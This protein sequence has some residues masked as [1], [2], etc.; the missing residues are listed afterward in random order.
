ERVA[1]R[2]QPRRRW[3]GPRVIDAHAGRQLARRGVELRGAAADQQQRDPCMLL[4]V[5]LLPAAPL[6]ALVVVVEPLALAAAGARLAHLEALAVAHVASTALAGP[7][8]GQRR[9][10]PGLVGDLGLGAARAAAAVALVVDARALGDAAA[11]AGLD[12]L[13][14]VIVAQVARVAL[15]RPVVDRADPRV[16][17]LG[18]RARP[19]RD[20][21]A[22]RGRHGGP[23]PE[24]G[25]H[26][27]VDVT[28]APGDRD[29]VLDLAELRP[30]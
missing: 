20:A 27:L 5:E 18:L 9:A 10:R 1:R 15:T 16:T 8:A 28:R 3:P 24:V 26:R 21:G 12:D 13:V 22:V 30:R 4:H 14:A 25:R 17:D 7:D 19:R 2:R 11:R 6:Q 29:V 23:L